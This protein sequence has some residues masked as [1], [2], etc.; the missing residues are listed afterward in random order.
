MA[1]TVG[2]AVAK[3]VVNDKKN[4]IQAD[5]AAQSQQQGNHYSA[6]DQPS[7]IGKCM[8]WLPIRYVAWLAG[9]AL[10]ISP[11]LDWFLF[12]ASFVARVIGGYLL[13]FGIVATFIESPVFQLTRKVEYFYFYFIF[14]L[15]LLVS[16]IMIKYQLLKLWFWL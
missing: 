1:V 8:L 7:F 4:E 10:I 13:F 12:K 14:I 16:V 6:P 9:I 2:G 11:I 3:K 5:Y 15:F